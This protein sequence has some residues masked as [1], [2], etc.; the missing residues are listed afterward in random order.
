MQLAKKK[1]LATKVLKAGKNRIVF[2]LGRENEIKEAI[3]RQDILDLYNSGAIIIKE[4]LGRRRKIRKKRRRK[5]GSIRK[6]VKSEK[7][8]YIVLVRKLRRGAKELLNR[9]KIDREKYKKIRQMIKA[10]KFKSNR[11][12]NE[13]LEEL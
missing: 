9:K 12:L 5:T 7:K 1:S 3:T 8:D 13:S 2:A 11:H 4:V 6:K 10:Q